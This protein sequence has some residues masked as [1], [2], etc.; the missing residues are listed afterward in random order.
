MKKLFL[1]FAFL[2]FVNIS[3]YLGLG[4]QGAFLDGKVFKQWEHITNTLSSQINNSGLEVKGDRQ[5]NSEH[6]LTLEL[7]DRFLRECS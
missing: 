7:M 6:A 4:M 1:G 3:S 5:K 2:G